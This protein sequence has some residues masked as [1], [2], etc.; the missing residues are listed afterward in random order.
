MRVIV[1][2]GG[3]AGHINPGIAIA[4]YIKQKKPSSE[5]IFVG[6]QRGLETRLV[7]REGFEL[8][9]IKVRGFKRKIS[10][11]NVAAVKEVFQG[12]YQAWRLIKDFKPDVV[13]GTGGYVC[14]P[15]LFIASR[16][17]IPT[18]IHEQNAYPGVT[19]RI[20]APFVNAVAVSFKESA[21]YFK[22][23]K[24]LILTGNPIRCEMLSADRSHARQKLGISADR[25]LVVI[26]GGSR[27]AERI[28]GSVVEMVAGP[29][30]EEDFSIIFATGEAQ[31]DCVCEKLEGVS[32]PS[33]KVVPYIYDAADV[34]AAADLMV[35]RAGAITVSEITALGVPSIVIPSPYVTANHQEHNARAL[36]EQGAAVVILERD[37]NGSLLYHQIIRLLG[38]KDL[39]A[40]M[41]KNARKLA[42]VNSAEKIYS[43][44]QEMSR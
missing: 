17:K 15:V 23:S 16:M 4:K 25:Q 5:I 36:E 26:V 30:G 29:Y 28:N 41:S 1:A 7:P 34:Y 21:R 31:Y 32:K 6:T 11:D 38:D 20:L 8:R 12:T 22:H 43:V 10:L 33:L 9:V 19:N 35:C 44:L 42:I 37:L 39:L 18:L 2:G 3:T 40:R 24:N 27:G 14:G 13:I